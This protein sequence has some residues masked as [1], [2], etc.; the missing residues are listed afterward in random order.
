MAM[1]TTVYSNAI[2][3]RSAALEGPP[4]FVSYNGAPLA[5]LTILSA[6][7]GRKGG[8]VTAAGWQ[9]TL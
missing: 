2:A 3:R 1:P 7:T 5:T 9:V 6:S 8:K 4:T